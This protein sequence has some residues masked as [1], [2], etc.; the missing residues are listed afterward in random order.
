MIRFEHLS[1]T[2]QTKDGAFEAL[3]DVSFVKEN[4]DISGVIG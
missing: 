3:K 1:K 4:G 2:F